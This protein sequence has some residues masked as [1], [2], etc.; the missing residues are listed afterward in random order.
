MTIH[1]KDVDA[2]VSTQR[3]ALLGEQQG[4]GHF[5]FE[6]EA[7]TTI[8][9]EYVLLRHFLGEI[10]AA[11]E[12]KIGRYVRTLQNADGSWPLFHGGAGDISASVK[13]YWA[14]KLIGDDI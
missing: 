11:R 10:D 7:D 2:V 12:E 1:I 9:S 8:P 6:L 5:V 13:A 4:D 3:S 14:L